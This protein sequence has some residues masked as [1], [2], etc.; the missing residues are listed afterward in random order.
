MS[1]CPNASS[2]QRV[3]LVVC[4]LPLVLGLDTELPDCLIHGHVI[5]Q[6]M[7]ADVEL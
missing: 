6:Q 4:G 3:A 5:R 1:L 2:P 7:L